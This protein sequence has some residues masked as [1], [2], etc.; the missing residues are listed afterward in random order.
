MNLEK[1]SERVIKQ[2]QEIELFNHDTILSI[3][4]MILCE[5]QELV[6]ATENGFL[7]DDLT[8]VISESSDCLYLLIRLFDLL[9]I[10]GKAIDIKIERNYQKYFNQNSTDEAREN[11]KAKGGD[12]VFF[13]SLLTNDEK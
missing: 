7:T 2:N 1:L 5:A 9:G 13:E 8:A 12:K 10:D 6:E 3:A 4:Q 11:W